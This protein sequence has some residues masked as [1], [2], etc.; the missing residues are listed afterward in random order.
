[1]LKD[2]LSGCFHSDILAFLSTKKENADEKVRVKTLS[3]G[4]TVPD[5]FYELARNM[6]ICISYF[7]IERMGKP[8]YSSALILRLCMMIANPNIRKTFK[9]NARGLELNF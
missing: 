5:K 8:A 2:C 7:S 6:K 4:V 9:I 3:L 1:M